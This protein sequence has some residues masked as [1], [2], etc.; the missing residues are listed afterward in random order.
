LISWLVRDHFFEPEFS[1][2]SRILYGLVFPVFALVMILV[3]R[4]RNELEIRAAEL[5]RTNEDLTLE[6]A[7]RKGSEDGLRAIIDN[8]P[9]FLWSDLP[10]GHCDFLNQR[11]LTYSRRCLKYCPDCPVLGG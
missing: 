6:I 4:G 8:A 7:R 10:D 5:T 2:E 9:V 1:A 3:V 11:W